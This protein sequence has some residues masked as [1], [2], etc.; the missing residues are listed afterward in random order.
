MN[1]VNALAKKET[2]KKPWPVAY[3]Q[4]QLTIAR[5]ARRAWNKS[6]IGG[7]TL[8]DPNFNIRRSDE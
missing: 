6:T 7:T 4:I 3:E 8:V 1:M 5:R 2:E